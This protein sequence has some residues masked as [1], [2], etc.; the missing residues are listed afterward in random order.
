MIER[1]CPVLE[2]EKVVALETG[3]SGVYSITL[4]PAY[5]ENNE[6][7]KPT[8]QESEI[9]GF[10]D[11][12]ST[13]RDIYHNNVFAQ[14]GDLTLFHNDSSGQKVAD[15]P[16]GDLEISTTDDDSSK[17]RVQNTDLMYDGD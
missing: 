7:V 17:Y 6:K 9:I 2:N 4:I 5:N 12:I 1:Y 8:I 14:R 16:D 11:S 10:G 13:E 3:E 15:L